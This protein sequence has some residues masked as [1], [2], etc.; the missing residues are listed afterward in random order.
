MK[1]PAKSDGQRDTGRVALALLDAAAAGHHPAVVPG[2]PTF[3]V[4]FAETDLGTIV[5]EEEA[6]P[7]R[8][9]DPRLDDFLWLLT[10]PIATA[11]CAA[12]DGR[13]RLAFYVEV[14]PV[15]R[16]ILGG[17]PCPCCYGKGVV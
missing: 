11:L 14:F 4:V 10:Q 1:D 16:W 12:C 3:P 5:I 13:G 7:R 9:N 2:D 15:R 17:W 6:F 8:T